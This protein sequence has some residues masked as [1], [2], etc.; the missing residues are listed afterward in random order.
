MKK[1]SKIKSLLYKLSLL[2]PDSIY[3]RFKYRKNFGCW[4]NLRKPNTFN[5][6]LTWLKLNDHNPLYTRMV[7]KAEA[8][9]YVAEIIG[10]EYIIPTIDVW[11]RADDINFDSLPE[12]F[13]LKATHDSGRVIICHDKSKL[14]KSWAIE[15]MRKSIKRDFYAVTREWP[16]KNVKP[17]II[18][19]ELL[20]SS[21]SNDSS[22]SLCDN[23]I[24]DYKFFCFGGKVEFMKVDFDRSTNHHA[25]YYDRSF[26]M[27]EFGEIECPPVKE[28]MIPKPSCFE[29]MIELAERISRNH[30]F[31]RVDFYEVAGKVYFGETTFY[32][33]SG[34]GKFSPEDADLTIGSLLKL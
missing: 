26:N 12:K 17:R 25:N 28:R 23:D 22:A 32:P 5:E 34:T 21:R 16:Y 11:D 10:E 9:R 8:K 19:E 24:N 27:L 14:D 13:V 7:D 29:E 1:D 30:R 15:E 20:E 2:V 31:L 33:A 3:V 18:A 6:K 4:P